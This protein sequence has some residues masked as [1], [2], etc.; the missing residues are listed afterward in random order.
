MP[1]ADPQQ[2]QVFLDREQAAAYV[3]LRQSAGPLLPHAPSPCTLTT[4]TLLWWDGKPW[5]V[6]NLGAPTVTLRAP[7][8]QVIDLS[9]AVFGTLLQQ[10]S[11]TIASPLPNDGR[12]TEEQARLTRAS[13]KQLAVATQR[14]KVL[15]HAA[16]EGEAIAPRTLRRWREEFRAAEA[17]YGHGF[18]GLIPRWSNSGNRLPRL[19]PDT[20]QLLEQYITPDSIGFS[21]K[22]TSC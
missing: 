11:V 12:R 21:G 7:E 13:A 10:K 16:A 4:G 20:E 9:S 8:K 5:R 22:I 1:L 15:G 6:L 19:S 2:V 3:A 17:V 14:Y 18:T